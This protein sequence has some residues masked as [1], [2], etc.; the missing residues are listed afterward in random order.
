MASINPAVNQWIGQMADASQVV[1][2]Y[3]YQCLQEEVFHAG[4]PGAEEEQAALAKVLGDALV[5][6]AKPGQGES[7]AASFRNNAFLTAAATA[8]V[9]FEHPARVRS[10]LARL[11]GYI[12]HEDSVPPLASALRDLEAREMARQALER[13][14]SERATGALIAALDS[15]GP[16]FC[17]GV[18]NSLAKRKGANAAAALRKAAADK[19]PEVR[20]AALLALADIPD[21]AHDAIIEKALEGAPQPERRTLHIARARLAEALRA[22]GNETAAARIYHAILAGDAPEPQKNAARLGLKA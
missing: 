9:Q 4:R 14:P 5:A 6:Q 7:G 8:S 15:A 2:Y 10:N 17:V 19:Q 13:H 20:T 21:P 18:V 16:T 22:A 11:L 12:P 1:A 3:A